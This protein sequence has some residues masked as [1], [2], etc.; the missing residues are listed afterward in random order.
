MTTF[1]WT[2]QI[3]VWVVIPVAL[4]T[5]IALSFVFDPATHPFWNPLKHAI[6]VLRPILFNLLFW[7]VGCVIGWVIVSVMMSLPLNVV[8]LG[9][10]AMLTAIAV[11]LWQRLPRRQA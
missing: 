5:V 2:I 4:L 10:L 9:I 11:L 8:A 1:G 6:R 3:L 7:L